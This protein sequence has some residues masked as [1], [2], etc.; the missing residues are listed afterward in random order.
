M[1]YRQTCL[2]VL[3]R[4]L[5]HFRYR[6]FYSRCSD[7]NKSNKRRCHRCHICSCCVKCAK[8]ELVKILGLI[9]I[10]HVRFCA[11]FTIT[12]CFLVQLMLFIFYF[13]WV[14]FLCKPLIR[15]F[16][17]RN[18]LITGNNFCELDFN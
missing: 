13:F 11:T 9:Y 1:T 8:A 16:S 2:K 17:M 5:Q 6:L 15:L 18:L 12:R 14:V 4:K 10:F 7:F 3:N